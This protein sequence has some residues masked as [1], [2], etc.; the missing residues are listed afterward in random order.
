[1]RVAADTSAAAAWQTLAG[2]CDHPRHEFWEDAFSYLAVAHE[3]LHGPAQVT[4]AW[5]A[6]LA[7]RRK[8]RLATMDTD[9]AATHSDAAHLIP[10]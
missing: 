10:N 5:L 6:E 4:D 7:R 3:A 8:G 2:V 9:F 1:M